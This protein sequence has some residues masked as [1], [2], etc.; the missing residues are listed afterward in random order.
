MAGQTG[1][2]IVTGAATGI[3]QAIALALLEAGWSVVLTG[4]R[5]AA[6]DEVVAS[7]ARAASALVVP[8]DVTDPASVA[9][10][11]RT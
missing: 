11:F 5:K 7:H 4:R 2:A 10:L 6:L 3:G 1:V 9:G 8:S